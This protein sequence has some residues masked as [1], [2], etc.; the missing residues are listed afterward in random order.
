MNKR[1][2]A[3]IIIG[4][5]AL[6]QIT[7]CGKKT[8]SESDSTANQ[9]AAKTETVPEVKGNAATTLGNISA[10][11][12]KL[13]VPENTFTDGTK[14]E[15]TAEAD[16]SKY[17]DDDKYEI[18]GT[19]VHVTAD[20]YKGEAFG[21]D[22][23][24]TF[25]M[26]E[27]KD[28]L[29]SFVFLYIDD[30][31]KVS[32][33][34]PDNYNT[35]DGTMALNLPHLSL[36]GTAK[37]TKEE[38]VE[39]FLN[40]YSTAAAIA[41]SDNKQ[42]SSELEPYIKEKIKALKLSEE[43]G[44]ELVLS[45]INQIGAQFGDDEGTYTELATSAYKSID[46]NDPSSFEDKI[47][48]I[49]SGQLYDM[50]NYNVA[51]GNADSEF[52]DA[53]K[54][55]TIV[56][57]IAGGDTETA[58]K[59]IGDAIGSAVP[60]ADLTTKAIGYVGAK[61]N[62]TFTNWKSNQIEELYQKYKNGYEDMWGNE[63]IAGDEESLKTYIYTSSGLSSSKGIYRFYNMD[64]SAET[65]EKYGWGKKDYEELDEHYREIFD[66]R[67]EEG[68]LN[69]FRTRMAEEAEAEKIKE[70]ERVCVEEMMQSYGCLSSGSFNK[71]FG[72]QS[73]D[74]YNLT[75]RL[76]LVMRVRG[77]LTKY[78]DEDALSKSQEANA[79]NWGTL[80]NTWVSLVTENGHDEAEKQFI[81]KLKEFG[82]L[83]KS[84][85]IGMSID[86]V[87]GTYSGDIKLTG[88]RVTEETYQLFLSQDGGD[89]AA[90]GFDVGSMSKADC[91][92][93]L[94]SYVDD[95]SITLGQELTISE[96]GDN[97]V[98]VT[99]TLISA[100]AGQYPI[101]ASAVISGNKLILTSEEGNTEI[102]ISKDGSNIVL[103][104][105]KAV[106]I[107]EVEDEGERFSLLVEASIN[108]KK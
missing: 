108:V 69:Y 70:K 103:K 36:W 75:E 5:L 40:K 80:M 101:T 86:D 23:A 89:L 11:G 31:G 78:V 77:M 55:G 38:Q 68:L 106:F 92:A 42:A 83:N 91:D 100:D 25:P 85:D 53:G 73:D 30:E 32:Y 20:S 49:I 46:D 57:A 58:M 26:S 7:A 34:L 107:V 104:S 96:N 8:G 63:V 65:C 79:Y 51:N 13:D 19:P 15:V 17:K 71:F 10:D 29:G 76:E 74:D 93:E 14:I 102:E 18:I 59:E 95:G 64:K 35:A 94:S 27:N 90:Y 37:L 47:E 16:F 81:S 44:R 28:N 39:M 98:T 66:Q 48:D 62:E 61:V 82:V 54:L 33:M 45:V 22:I 12:Y 4:V 87:V 41:K 1:I 6:S 56:G 60:A 84:Y 21:T 43:T 9:P 88:L 99:G 105:N 3:L 24:L 97:A 67:A 52:K 2:L 50:I 72:E